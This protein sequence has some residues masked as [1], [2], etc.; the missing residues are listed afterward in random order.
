MQRERKIDKYR[1][2]KKLGQK[3]QNRCK[4]FKRFPLF[5][6]YDLATSRPRIITSFNLIR[7]GT[8]SE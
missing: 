4:K 5:A 2:R 3:L 1:E 6:F 7:R 8:A